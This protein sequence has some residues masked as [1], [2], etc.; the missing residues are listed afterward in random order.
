M[1]T[2]ENPML[3]KKGVGGSGGSKKKRRLSS[4]ESMIEMSTQHLQTNTVATEDGEGEG[5][6]KEEEVTVTLE[7]NPMHAARGGAAAAAAATAPETVT[8]NAARARW[9]K[10]KQATRTSGTFRNGGKQ[11][12]KR[13]SKVMKARQNVLGDGDNSVE[14][15][16]VLDI[17]AAVS[18]HVDEKTGRRYT[19]NKATGHTQWLSDD[20]DGSEATHENVQVGESTPQTKKLFRTVVDDDDDV[21]VYYENMETGEVVWNIPDD[22]KLAE[23]PG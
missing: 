6:E 10:L 11:R 13:L 7:I 8:P 16:T 12:M 5:E 17:K 20:D 23:L 4:R 9:N 22:G 18:I 1:K 14:V 3:R 15:K 21:P 19:Y 2:L